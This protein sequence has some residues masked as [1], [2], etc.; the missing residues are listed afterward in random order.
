LDA[1]SQR[2]Q[3]ASSTST[4]L[5]L[6][7]VFVQLLPPFAEHRGRRFQGIVA[8][9]SPRWQLAGTAGL[10]LAGIDNGCWW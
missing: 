4:T 6:A 7:V 3:D 9:A 10:L 1:K 5:L 2:A 8:S